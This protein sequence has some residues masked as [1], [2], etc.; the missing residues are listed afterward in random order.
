MEGGMG[1][2]T[3]QGW[4]IMHEESSLFHKIFKARYFPTTSFIDSRLGVNHSYVWRGIWETKNSLLKG[5]RW[6]VG[7]GLSIN[8]WIDYWLPKQKLLSTVVDIPPEAGLQKDVEKVRSVFLATATE[9]L[10]IRLPMDSIPDILIWEHEISSIFSVKSAYDFFKT[11]EHNGDEAEMC[12]NIL[13][14]FQNLKNRRVIEEA[15]RHC[16]QAK[17]E[18]LPHALIYCPGVVDCWLQVFPSI[19]QATVRMQIIQ[20]ATAIIKR[21]RTGEL[22]K[23]F[24]LAWGLWYRRNQSIYEGNILSTQQVMEH[25]FTLYQEHKATIEATKIKLKYKCQWQPPPEG[26]LKLN[27]DG[28]LFSDQCKAGVGA[29]LRDKEGKIIFVASKSEPTIAD[30][31]EIELLAILRGLQLCV[32]LGI[33]ALKVEYDSLLAVQELEKEGNSTTLWGGLIKEIMTMLQRYPNWSIHHKGRE[34][35]GVA[36]ALAR[37]AWTLDDICIWWNSIPDCISQAIWVD[38]NL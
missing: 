11:I 19:I 16:C 7:N 21:R 1:F 5:C 31:L 14:T 20:L 25:A 36:H 32:S 28:A 29:V 23:F 15:T 38:S 6:R 17:D 33:I 22:E 3:K 24:L 30:P 9:V 27:I 34:A 8:I 13:P 35:N 2:K 12:K 10:S 4:R 37:F 18:N 26:V